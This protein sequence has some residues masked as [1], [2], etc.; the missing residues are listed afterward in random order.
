VKEVPRLHIVT[1]DEVLA[2]PGFVGS[3]IGLLE[4]GAGRVALHVRGH[5]TTASTLFATTLAVLAASPAFALVIVNDRVDI[6]LAAGAHGVQLGVRSPPV[7]RVRAW[8]DGRDPKGG[9]AHRLIG[10]SAHDVEAA[11]RATDEGA[12]YVIAGSIWASGTHAGAAP[13]G[14]ALIEA[15]SRRVR[16]AVIAIGGVRPDRVAEALR[17]GAHGVAVVGHVWNGDGPA[18]AANACREL[19][20]ALDEA[21]SNMDRI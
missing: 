20:A 15:I 16:Q 1:N 12:D 17:A 14:P 9:G 13:A 19:L 21:D 4:G 8:L 10:F 11:I 18:F 3:A 7:A 6:A 2:R 5:A